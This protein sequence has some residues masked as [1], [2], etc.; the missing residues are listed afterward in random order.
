TGDTAASGTASPTTD[1]WLE[2]KTDGTV[3]TNPSSGVGLAEPSV[4]PSRIRIG[5]VITTGSTITGFVPTHRTR[6]HGLG[7]DI[8][9]SDDPA[10]FPH[11][12]KALAS[13]LAGTGY[14]KLLCVGDQTTRGA[15]GTARNVDSYPARLMKLLNAGPYKCVEG[16][17]LAGV[18]AATDS[19]WVRGTGW[20]TTGGLSP[21]GL[22]GGSNTYFFAPTSASGDLT[23]APG[24]NIDTI[25]V[26]YVQQPSAGTFT[27]NVDG[28]SALATINAAGTAAYMIATISCS[29]GT[30]TIHIPPP[31][32]AGVQ[33][34]GIEAYDSSVPAI[35]LT[36]AGVDS[37][38]TTSWNN[39]AQPYSCFGAIDAIQPDLSIVM[40][41]TVDFVTASPLKQTQWYNQIQTIT[42]KLRQY[43]DV[44]LASG[45]PGNAS[46]FSNLNI[47]QAQND[48]MIKRIAQMYQCG[49]VSMQDRLR[50]WYV[51][52]ANGFM[53][54]DSNL[55]VA[56]HCDVANAMWQMVK[57]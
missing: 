52:N 43:G 49:V 48:A 34:L 15:G 25:K 40:L 41:T 55:S 2:A 7:A 8:G 54:D 27:V 46:T 18:V 22:G 33:I 24:Y 30:H 39:S 21:A 28:G 1:T 38:G 19:R 4:L 51:A 20:V 16:I 29:S 10:I 11:Y 44:I 31:T 17:S 47:V 37:A 23:F 9:F 12:R 13:I 42:A 36:N 50:S 3:A 5:K 35:H 32:V 53:A 57:P 6:V 56:G 26:H 14:A 45:V